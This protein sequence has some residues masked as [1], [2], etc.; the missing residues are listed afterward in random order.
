MADDY[1]KMVPLRLL[2]LL[3]LLPSSIS[4]AHIR[5]VPNF[6]QVE[7]P[8]RTFAFWLK[9]GLYCAKVKEYSANQWEC[10]N[11]MSLHACAYVQSQLYPSVVYLLAIYMYLYRSSI[12]G[13]I[14]YV[15]YL[16]SLRASSHSSMQYSYRQLKAV[17][18][19]P[20]TRIPSIPGKSGTWYYKLR[21]SLYAFFVQG[22]WL[23]DQIIRIFCVSCI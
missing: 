16:R 1:S 19:G 14:A 17:I 21:H 6:S 10:L 7:A 13:A 20:P 15:V 12:H 11:Q 18:S 4:T 22:N 23:L 2:L 9:S 3:L 8:V 5:S